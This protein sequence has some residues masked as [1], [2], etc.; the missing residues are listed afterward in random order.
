MSRNRFYQLNILR[1]DDEQTRRCRLRGDRFALISEVWDRF[2]NN[3]KRSYMPNAYLT[4]DQ[5]LYPTKVRCQ[6]IQ[7]MPNKPD[8][9]GIKFWV[10]VDSVSKY[11]V[12]IIPYLGRDDEH[13]LGE[14]LS[15]NVVKRLMEHLYGKGYNV[16][17]DN[18]FISKIL[19]DELL[20]K[21][22]TILG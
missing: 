6:F 4:V 16:T 21:K 3:C 7:F 5:Q 15:C 20:K 9:F 19:A 12:N 2:T 22:I 14:T 10:L 1:F 13:P 11:V 18:F 8:K 17:M